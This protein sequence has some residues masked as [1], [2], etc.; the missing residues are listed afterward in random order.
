MSHVWGQNLYIIQQ[1]GTGYLKIGRSGNVENRLVSLQTGSATELR[2][3]LHAPNHG[4][5]EKKIHMQLISHK[6]WN[7]QGEWFEETGLADLP[8]WLYELLDLDQQDW[9][10]KP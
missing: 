9:W 5:L 1:Y 8:V 7:R 10:I 4:N 2:I 3:I 6:C